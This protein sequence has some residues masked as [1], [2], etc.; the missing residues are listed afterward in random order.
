MGWMSE[1]LRWPDE[2]KQYLDSATPLQAAT[3]KTITDPRKLLTEL[4]RIKKRGFGFSCGERVMDG[5]CAISAP[6][7]NCDG[8]VHYCLTIT[9]TPFRLQAKGREKLVAAVK[10]SSQE[11]STKFGMGSFSAQAAKESLKVVTGGRR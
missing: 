2:L 6:I 11:I 7:F 4:A 10:K 1:K 3:P 5:L 8:K 9:L